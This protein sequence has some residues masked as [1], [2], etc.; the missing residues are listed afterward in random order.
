MVDRIEGVDLRGAQFFVRVR[1]Q[2]AMVNERCLFE[3]C[4]R[5]MGVGREPIRGVD[6]AASLPWVVRGRR[7]DND[8]CTAAGE[9]SCGVL[10]VRRVGENALLYVR[11]ANLVTGSR[12][13]GPA[14]VCGSKRSTIIVSELN[15]YEVF[16]LNQSSDCIE[17]ALS[18]I[19]A[20]GT[21]SDSSVFDWDG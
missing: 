5:I 1:K 9:V 3:L 8:S 17:P 11:V 20:R 21:T 13:V 12:T 16:G 18:R 19:A 15:D 2:L 4:S 10:K 6:E 14:I 7:R